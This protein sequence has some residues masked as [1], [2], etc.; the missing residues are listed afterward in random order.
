MCVDQEIEWGWVGDGICDLVLNC[1]EYEFDGGDC[2]NTGV[3]NQCEHF[4]CGFED[5][6]S[7]CVDGE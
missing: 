1:A 5:S 2:L 4:A 3:G 7:I 6:Q